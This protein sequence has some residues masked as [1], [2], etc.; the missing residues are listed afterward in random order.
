MSR[1]FV[2][3]REALEESAASLAEGHPQHARVWAY[4]GAARAMLGHV[5]AAREAF[6]RCPPGD[7]LVRALASFVAIAEGEPV[8]T[9][10]PRGAEARRI[11]A[12]AAG[13]GR[14]PR[15]R[16]EVADD[17][18]WFRL[19]G[20]A[21]D[22]TRRRALRGILEQL[23]RQHAA[24][25]GEPLSLDAVLEAGWPGERMS[26]DSGARRV[27]V[28]INRLRK[29]GLGDLLLT[30]GDGYMLAPSVHVARVPSESRARHESDDSLA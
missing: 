23:V 16:L 22:L 2:L 5:T 19:E 10:A 28:T 4:T 29:L 8:S 21:V 17:A 20:E 3:A 27:Y 12:L 11:A 14:E 13:L 9:E 1:D 6:A 26:P 7:E 18:R 24:A 30:T 15:A 25:R